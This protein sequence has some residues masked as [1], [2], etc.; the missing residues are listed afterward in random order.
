MDG[1]T[2]GRATS[3]NY[4]F[5]TGKSLALAMLPP[6]LAAP[7]TEVEVELL[8]KSFRARVIPDSPFD[9]ANERLRDVN[10]ANG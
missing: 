8:D 5:R 9:P 10:G 2:V 4:G 7:G 6:D 1:E 3:G